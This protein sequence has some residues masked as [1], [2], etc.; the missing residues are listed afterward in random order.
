MSIINSD[1][2]RMDIIFVATEEGGHLA[3]LEPLFFCGNYVENRWRDRGKRFPDCDSQ[4]KRKEGGKEEKHT[5]HQLE[6]VFMNYALVAYFNN[7]LSMKYS[8]AQK[9]KYY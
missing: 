6:V 5:S 8:S 3:K 2:K 9:N 4:R 7:D 1:H